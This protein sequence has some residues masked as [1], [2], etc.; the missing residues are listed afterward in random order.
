[1]FPDGFGR[2]TPLLSNVKIIR[3]LSIDSALIPHVS[4]AIAQLAFESQWVEVD[5]QID[6]IVRECRDALDSWYRGMNIGQ[7]AFFAGS[8][9]D[10]WLSLDGATYAMADYP[11]LFAILDAQFKDVPS[12]TFTLP[13]L[14]GLF[15]R[16]SDID[17]ALGDIAGEDSVS[18][19]IAELPAHVHG[20][21]PPVLADIDVEAPGVPIPS[22]GIGA[23]INTTSTGDGQA[24]ENKPPFIALNIGIFAGRNA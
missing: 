17:F 4:D 2:H 1:M 19:S 13:D 6:V 23:Q 14:S 8:L 5:E 24:H 16:V 20:Y 11:E 7:I 15:L 22:V 12:E 10:G 9:P 21:I 18:L 3:A